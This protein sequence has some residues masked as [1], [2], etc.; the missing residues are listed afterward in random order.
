MYKRRVIVDIELLQVYLILVRQDGLKSD[1]TCLENWMLIPIYMKVYMKVVNAWRVLDILWVTLTVQHHMT[2][3]WYVW[4]GISHII[5]L[6]SDII[7][8]SRLQS[9][10][11][12]QLRTSHVP[13]VASWSISIGFVNM[14]NFIELYLRNGHPV[15]PMA[16][17]WYEYWLPIVE[18]WDNA[19][20]S[21]LHMYNELFNWSNNFKCTINID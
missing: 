18:G 9:L 10:T 12:L 6:K 2:S 4:D 8:L 15:P 1:V 17:K 11:F 19:Y 3:W 7:F 16:Y 14:N 21:G 20:I 13:T 5:S